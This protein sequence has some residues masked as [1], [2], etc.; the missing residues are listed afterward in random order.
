MPFSQPLSSS[1]SAASANIAERRDSMPTGAHAQSVCG[2]VLAG[3]YHWGDTA[4]ERMFRGPLLPVAQV[5]VIC[6]PLGWLRDGGVTEARICANSM[7]APVQQHLGS[8]DRLG[9]ALEYYEDHSPRGP[10]GC[11]RDAA[12]MS[13]ADTFVVVE[14]SMI[15]TVD[16]SALL[17]AHRASGASATL[18]V[19]VDRRR[20]AIEGADLRLPGGIYVLNRDVLETVATNGY[21]DIKEGLLERLYKTGNRVMTY[22]LSGLSPRVL[23]Y[24]TY[25]SV[26]RWLTAKAVE[27][28]TYLANYVRV[29]DALIHPSA[30]V[31]PSARLVGPVIVGP[32]AS[33]G[34]DAMVVGASTIGRG[35]VVAAGALVSRS[36]V[37]SNCWVGAAAVVDDTLLADHC[38]VE[39]GHQLFGAVH[40]TPANRPVNQAAVDVQADA[41]ENVTV[42]D[43]S[44]WSSLSLVASVGFRREHVSA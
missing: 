24:P 27:N 20:R 12:A 5:P 15:P 9:V 8:G 22:E 30:E 16:L 33:I 1:V 11:A 42:T 3:S 28:Q 32:H 35:S 39:A 17:D 31:D 44:F 2:I 14:G 21:Q 23:D 6:Y 19:E 29:G 40:I 43:R 26:N 36:I 37:W 25:T 34:E 13:N 38:I 18:V 7:T 10:A 4:F 41:V